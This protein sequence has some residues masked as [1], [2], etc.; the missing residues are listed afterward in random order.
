MNRRR[1]PVGIVLFVLCAFVGAAWVSAQEKPLDNF[2][3]IKLTKA[4]MG[5]DVIIAKIKSAKAVKFDTSTEDLVAL[6][7][8]GV[9]KAVISAMLD[10][11]AAPKAAAG[12]SA[13]ADAQVELKATDGSADL[14]PAYGLKETSMVPFRGQVGWLKYDGR[15][16]AVRTKDRR[17]SVEIMTE[18]DP[19]K[20]G[21][22]FVQLD[23]NGSGSDAYRSFDLNTVTGAWTSTLSAEPDKSS[24]IPVDV[25]QVSPGVWKLTPQ[26]TLKP[27]E[28]GLYYRV[29]EKQVLHGF[30]IDR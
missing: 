27:G 17:P 10:R 2:E 7:S 16:A 11:S 12:G 25:S 20:S 14:K 23:Q 18:N 5:D 28:Y 21:W 13:T 6:K 24:Q 4:D 1:I 8:A 30:G 26:K 22:Y 15:T 19:T 29:S 3:I 9:S